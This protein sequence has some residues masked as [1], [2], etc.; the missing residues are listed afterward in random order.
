ME[1]I[2]FPIKKS[3]NSETILNTFLSTVESLKQLSIA[4]FN[5]YINGSETSVKAKEAV[6]AEM[7]RRIGPGHEELK[8]ELIPSWPPGCKLAPDSLN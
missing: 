7:L 5:T 1:S 3:N 6:E 8:K 4:Q 2:T